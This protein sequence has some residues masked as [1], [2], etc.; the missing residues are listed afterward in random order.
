MALVPVDP[1]AAR[2]AGVANPARPSFIS[3]S[4]IEAVASG[5]CDR[6]CRASAGHSRTPAGHT[7]RRGRSPPSPIWRGR[8]PVLV[9][10]RR[11]SNGSRSNRRDRLHFGGSLAP[12]SEARF[13]SRYRAPQP[14]QSAP[15]PVDFTRS[16]RRKRGQAADGRGRERARGAREKTS[17]PLLMMINPLNCTRHTPMRSVPAGLIPGGQLGAALS[18][19]PRGPPHTLARKYTPVQGREGKPVPG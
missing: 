16:D 19:F 1:A 14:G 6:S 12:F 2:V 5:A 9:D 15:R 11:K 17:R 3:A 18:Q 8:S 10:P 4:A 13:R 7:R